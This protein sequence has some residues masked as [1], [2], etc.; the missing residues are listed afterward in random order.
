MIGSAGDREQTGADQ[1]QIA[2]DLLDAA[3]RSLTA[4]DEIAGAHRR[5]LVAALGEVL[6]GGMRRDHDGDD[7]EAR[8]REWS[9]GAPSRSAR[10]QR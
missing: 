5:P 1:R 10:H 9:G 6:R 8:D 7:S 3:R 2:R 4:D